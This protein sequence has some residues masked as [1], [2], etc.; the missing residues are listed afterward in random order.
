MEPGHCTGVGLQGWKEGSFV[1][2]R[3]CGRSCEVEQ[4]REVEQAGWVGST[5]EYK[6]DAGRE[7]FD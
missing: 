5:G 1:S 7:V 4:P 3:G 6:K 2:C